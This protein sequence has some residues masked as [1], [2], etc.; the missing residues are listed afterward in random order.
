M[1]GRKPIGLVAMTNVERQRRHKEKQQAELIAL[2][3]EIQALK[4]PSAP[5]KS[6]EE[7]VKEIN[8]LFAVIAEEDK[9]TSSQVEKIAKI[10]MDHAAELATNDEQRKELASMKAKLLKH[11]NFWTD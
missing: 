9:V 1:R 11:L 7:A 2:R 4:A 3:N 5:Q 6:I 10:E 8:D